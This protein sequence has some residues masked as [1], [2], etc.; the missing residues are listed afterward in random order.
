MHCD[1]S[2]NNKVFPKSMNNKVFPKSMN[3]KVF[4][5]SMVWL[6]L[7]LQLSNSS[8]LKS[9]TLSILFEKAY[10]KL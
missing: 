10:S 6:N 3:N 9:H 1:K 7:A 8:P 5:K 4:P 2:M